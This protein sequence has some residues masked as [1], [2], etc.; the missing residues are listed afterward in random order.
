MIH[1]IHIIDGVVNGKRLLLF[2]SNLTRGDDD[3]CSSSLVYLLTIA[4]ISIQ[5]L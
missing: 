4:L 1:I 5:N 3:F 2:W